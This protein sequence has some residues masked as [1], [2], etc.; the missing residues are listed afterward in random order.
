MADYIYPAP[1]TTSA[2]LSLKI[3]HTSKTAEAALTPVAGTG[4]TMPSLQDVTVNAA[5]DV[6]TWTQLDA[7]AKKQIATTA[8]NSLG[9]NL[10]VNQ[11]TF[12]GDSTKPTDSAEKDGILGLSTAKTRVQFDLYFGD[13]SDGTG[14]KYISG[15]GYITGL[16]PTVSADAPVWV[17]PITITIDSDYT[18]SDTAL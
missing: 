17:T 15:F 2:A 5:N 16:A 6:F 4:M 18:V 14:G 11:N 8:T 9:M 13:E 10:V 12:F 7:A 1:G 3:Y